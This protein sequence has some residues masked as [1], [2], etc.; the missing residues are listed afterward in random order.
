MNGQQNE[1]SKFKDWAVWIP[2]ATAL[3]YF[4]A[5]FFEFVTCM[6]LGIPANLIEPTTGSILF[7]AFVLCSFSIAGSF[8]FGGIYVVVKDAKFWSGIF[9]LLGLVALTNIA[10]FFT[11]R[12]WSLDEGLRMALLGFYGW[13]ILFAYWLFIKLF[14]RNASWKRIF[15]ILF[16]DG[17]N[18]LKD[19]VTLLRT[20]FVFVIVI[21]V[22]FLTYWCA[23]ASV[24]VNPP[25][26]RILGNEKLVIV[27]KYNDVF[28]C[29]Y[30][31]S[32]NT[33]F[34]LNDRVKLVKIEGSA[35]LTTQ[36]MTP[37]PGY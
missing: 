18:V 21:G 10:Y 31:D 7:F 29:R 20:R 6:K 28:I 30:M 34:K 17:D 33:G 14:L 13:L 25:S 24:W 32:T 19:F 26:V 35:G 1:L 12:T 9:S 27:K 15:I 11:N 37:A 2:V 4:Y 16:E 36:E 23:L 22:L 5:W 8:F 3:I